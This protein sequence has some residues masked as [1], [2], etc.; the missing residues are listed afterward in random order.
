MQFFGFRACKGA[1]G[2]VTLTCA[3]NLSAAIYVRDKPLTVISAHGYGE[4]DTR[5]E[6]VGAAFSGK[7]VGC[8]FFDEIHVSLQELIEYLILG[9]QSIYPTAS[10]RPDL[11]ALTKVNQPGKVPTYAL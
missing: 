1:D 3:A 10:T 6:S 8:S 9:I 5:A 2:V 7:S 4:S 11:P